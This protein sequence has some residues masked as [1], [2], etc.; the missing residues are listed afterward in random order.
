MNRVTI[1]PSLKCPMCGNASLATYDIVEPT[2][3]GRLTLDLADEMT[4]L[5]IWC[6]VCKTA[7]E[8]DSVTVRYKNGHF[9]I[10][11]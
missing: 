3:E 11:S 1:T 4:G 10:Y 7:L 8:L 6:R 2:V 5:T 9:V